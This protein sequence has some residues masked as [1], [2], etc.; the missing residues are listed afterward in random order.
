MLRISPYLPRMLE[1][2]EQNN[3]EY[4]YLLRSVQ[5]KVFFQEISKDKMDQE[6]FHYNFL[7]YLVSEISKTL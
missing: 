3:S 1:N 5:W 2:T 6:N 4:G 7:A